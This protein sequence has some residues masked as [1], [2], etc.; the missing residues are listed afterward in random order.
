V[1][2]Q[3]IQFNMPIEA[4]NYVRTS[5]M[6]TALNPGQETVIKCTFIGLK[7]RADETLTH[8]QPLNIAIGLNTNDPAQPRK[9]MSIIGTFERVYTQ[10]ELNNSP[11]ITFTRTEFHG[12]NVIQGEALNYRFEF[13]NTGTQPLRIQNVRASCGC[14]ASAPEDSVVAPGASSTITARFDSRGKMGE[15]H[16]TVTVVSN[17][18]TQPNVV[19]HLKCNVIPD[20]FGGSGSPTPTPG[21]SPGQAPFG[22]A[23]LG[24]APRQ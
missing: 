24:V 19:L 3:R 2:R 18:P 11:R 15:Q 14:T 17:D 10:Q 16:K 4:P 20:P 1:S 8:Q 6:L 12:G 21:G 5:A 23:P 13:R 9:E 22:G 7:A